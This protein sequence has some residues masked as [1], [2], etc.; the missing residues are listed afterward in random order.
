MLGFC[1]L[2]RK[3]CWKQQ[4]ESEAF[5]VTCSNYCHFLFFSATEFLMYIQKYELFEYFISSS[6]LDIISICLTGITSVLSGLY[7]SPIFPH[8]NGGLENLVRCFLKW[9]FS[10]F[11]SLIGWIRLSS[12][13]DLSVVSFTNL[14]RCRLS[15]P[16]CHRRRGRLVY[17][18]TKWGAS[19]FIYFT[20]VKNLNKWSC[21]FD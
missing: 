6:H 18:Q 2:Q 7:K 20:S 3:F 1:F 12:E 16:C 10:G 13:A 17:A 14:K 15:F 4:I 21:D 19:I 5:R 9:G 11:S 8:F